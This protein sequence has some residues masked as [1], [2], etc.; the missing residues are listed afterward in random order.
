MAKHRYVP[1]RSRRARTIVGGALAAG[2]LLIAGPAATAFAQSDGAAPKPP[3]D[4]GDAGVVGRVLNNT[5]I[6]NVIEF[7]P[8]SILAGN[9]DD[10]PGTPIWNTLIGPLE[11]PVEPFV[12]LNG[13]PWPECQCPAGGGGGQGGG[14]GGG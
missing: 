10:L 13:K 7:G 11:E 8:K 5:P 1:A 2:G 14:A 3:S 12:W 6:G 4:L 9:G